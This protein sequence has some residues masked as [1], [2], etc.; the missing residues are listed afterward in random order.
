MP[1]E[2]KFETILLR[3]NIRQFFID[4]KKTLAID[5]LRLEEYPVKIGYATSC[6]LDFI[7]TNVTIELTQG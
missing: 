5:L 1:K 2:R 4:D 6:D 3:E 7:S